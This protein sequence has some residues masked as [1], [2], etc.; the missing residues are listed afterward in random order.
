MGCSSSSG[1]QGS[2]GS[3]GAACYGNGTCNAGLTC[4]TGT[5]IVNA[6]APDGGM[7]GGNDGGKDGAADSGRA[8]GDDSGGGNHDAA[9]A[10]ALSFS[11]T[12][13]E[14]CFVTNCASQCNACVADALCNKAASC[15][16]ACTTDACVFDCETSTLVPTAIGFPFGNLY[17]DPAGCID[18]HCR[19]EC[20]KPRTT[21]DPCYVNADCASG[22]CATTG[23]AGRGWCSTSGACTS[24]TQCGIDSAGELV[25]CNAATGGG[26]ACFPGCSSNTDCQYYVESSSLANATCKPG[27]SINGSADTACSF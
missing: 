26:Y 6:S 23:S 17:S 9:P 20:T 3:A 16:M 24:N 5:C 8:G 18:G 19:S 7:Q 2:A 4:A 21:G 14:S 27:T 1:P 10:C 15:V 22:V 12:T 25:W 13:C 11:D